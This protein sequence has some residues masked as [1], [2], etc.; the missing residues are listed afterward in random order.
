MSD[1]F[2]ALGARLAILAAVALQAT[3]K[4]TYGVWLEEL[5]TALFV[6]FGFALTAGVFLGLSRRGHGEIAWGTLILINVATAVMFLSF[7]AALKLIEPAIVGAVGVS[8]AP[9]VAILIAF[10]STGLAPTRTQIGVCAAILV[11]CGL[12]A[13]SAHNGSGYQTSVRDA[14][15]GLAASLVAGIGAVF[16]TVASRSL[17]LKGW[18]A[19]S[20]LAHRFYLIIPASLLLSFDADISAVVWSHEMIGLII[21]VTVLS[22]LAP[23]YLLQIGVQHCEPYTVL[24]TMAALPVMTFLAEGLFLKYQWS[25]ATFIGV[26]IITASVIW[27]LSTKKT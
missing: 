5:P 2:T 14:W 9:F 21:L 4:V 23:L 16:V 7:F 11:G 15:V 25:I 10:L 17:V 20:I 22:V 27:D 6:F 12:L 24:V 1:D 8:V 13:W 3:G 26:T 18:S 19:G